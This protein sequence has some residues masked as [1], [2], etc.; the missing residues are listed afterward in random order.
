ML[1]GKENS[2]SMYHYITDLVVYD[3][4][5]TKWLGC[6]CEI[7]GYMIGT[8]LVNWL[9]SNLKKQTIVTNH[10]WFVPINCFC[11]QFSLLLLIWI[12]RCTFKWHTLA[13]VFGISNW[14]ILI[15]TNIIKMLQAL[16]SVVINTN[17]FET[18]LLNPT[19]Q[20][21]F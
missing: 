2:T 3:F 9:N 12:K 6:R 11:S 14:C 1:Y 17:Y 10:F 15:W 18:T 20:S 8:L 4:L 16:V 21:L 13:R 7:F 5:L 19:Y